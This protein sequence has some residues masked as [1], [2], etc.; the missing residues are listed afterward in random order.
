MEAVCLINDLKPAIKVILFARNMVEVHV[1]NTNFAAMPWK[2][3]RCLS[4]TAA[5]GR[6]SC[7]RRIDSLQPHSLVCTQAVPPCLVSLAPHGALLRNQAAFWGKGRLLQ[8]FSV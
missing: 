6:G 1:L 3:H 4:G 5:L 2:G 8:L 7:Q